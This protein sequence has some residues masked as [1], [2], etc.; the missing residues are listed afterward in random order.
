MQIAH[1]MENARHLCPGLLSGLLDSTLHD[2][3]IH[4]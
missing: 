1:G 2:G 4:N 3:F